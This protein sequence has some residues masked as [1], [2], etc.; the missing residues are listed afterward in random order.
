H[1]RGLLERLPACLIRVRLDGTLLACNDAGLGLFGARNLGAVLNTN[2]ADRF[3]A[4]ERAKWQE[5]SARVWAKDAASFETQLVAD[6]DTRPVLVQG[7]AVRDDPDGIDSLLLNV[8]D[9]SQTHRLERS[10]RSAVIT[11]ASEEERDRAA[12]DQVEQA[13]AERM[14]L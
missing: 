8:R 1:L 12:R 13:V 9:Q 2:L 6:D 14:Q 4:A 5:F 11:R 10:I 3:V 7:I